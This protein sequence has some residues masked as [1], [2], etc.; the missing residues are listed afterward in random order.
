MHD[1]AEAVKEAKRR[2]GLHVR[3]NFQTPAGKTELE[4]VIHQVKEK[5]KVDEHKKQEAHY[6][7]I[8]RNS[9][10]QGGEG[11]GVGEGSRS[12][13]ADCS[14]IVALWYENG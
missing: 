9:I 3:E 6:R 14:T 2:R 7:R 5:K 4:A 12:S 13:G 10:S 1:E 11:G 8:R